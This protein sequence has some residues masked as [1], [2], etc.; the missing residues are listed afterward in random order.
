MQEDR[1]PEE[2]LHLDLITHHTTAGGAIVV[3]DQFAR[4]Y[5]SDDQACL[6]YTVYTMELRGDGLECEYREHKGGC[7][8]NFD[9]NTLLAVAGY[10]HEQGLV[11]V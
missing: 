5:D 9:A 8:E 6:I 7:Y 1:T 3:T 4:E 10:I 11:L 2:I